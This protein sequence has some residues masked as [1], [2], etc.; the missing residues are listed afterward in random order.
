MTIEGDGTEEI[1]EEPVPLAAAPKTGD[2]SA[3]WLVLILVT[4][5]GLVTINVISKKRKTV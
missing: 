3:M 5:M 4:A 1:P 2:N